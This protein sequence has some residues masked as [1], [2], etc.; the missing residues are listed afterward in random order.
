MH[1]MMMVCVNKMVWPNLPT[2]LAAPEDDFHEL[3]E[4]Y[5]QSDILFQDESD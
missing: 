5:D 3:H 2:E 4:S 1:A